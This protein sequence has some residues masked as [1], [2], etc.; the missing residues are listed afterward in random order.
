MGKKLAKELKNRRD[1]EGI[2]GTRDD[3]LGS[4]STIKDLSDPDNPET[5]S[6]EASASVADM[7]LNQEFK[8]LAPGQEF[9][10]KR[11]RDFLIKE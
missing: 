11:V 6:E 8:G 4:F 2:S 1:L 7:L 3:L 10:D 5:V 9:N